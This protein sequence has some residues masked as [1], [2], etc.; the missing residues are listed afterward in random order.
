MSRAQ[1]RVAESWSERSEGSERDKIGEETGLP[2]I[3]C[4][5]CGRGRVIER[6]CKETK[7][8]GRVFFHC[9]RNLSW[10]PDKCG[11]Y[12]WQKGYLQYLIQRKLIQV[13]DPDSKQEVEEEAECV[14]QPQAASTGKTQ[15]K[16]LEAKVENLMKLVLM[17]IM[18]VVAI[19]GVFVGYLLK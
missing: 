11:F 13:I 9:P 7:N 2:L 6:R 16:E 17:L 3:M 4:P 12:R 18:V 1:S 5:E 14:Q 10:L 15:N 19:V 8:Y